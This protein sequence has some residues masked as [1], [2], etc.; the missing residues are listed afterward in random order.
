MVAAVERIA[1][2]AGLDLGGVEYLVSERDGRPYFYD[3]NALSNFV[4]EPLRVLGFDPTAR[5]VDALTA[6]AARRAA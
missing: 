6:W 3:V 2:A 4:A 1:R 5:L